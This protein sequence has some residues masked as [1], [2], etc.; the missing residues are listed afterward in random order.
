VENSLPLTTVTVYFVA[1]LAEMKKQQVLKVQSREILIPFFY[2]NGGLCINI[3]PLEV[4]KYFKAPR[5]L[6]P[7][8][9][10][11]CGQGEIIS[12]RLYF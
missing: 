2:I 7:R 8:W 12:E 9:H 10:F 5:I 11:W 1:T 4:F 3:K 6:D